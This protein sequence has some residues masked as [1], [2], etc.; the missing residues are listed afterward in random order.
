MLLGIK[1]LGQLPPKL[2]FLFYILVTAR[3]VI[4]SEWGIIVDIIRVEDLLVARCS[5]VVPRLELPISVG[6]CTFVITILV[7][8]IVIIV[9]K[10][11]LGCVMLMTRRLNSLIYYCQQFLLTIVLR[12]INLFVLVKITLM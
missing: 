11:R 4:T 8:L 6:V 2:L 12:F 5:A 10:L 1:K 3:N 7:V 9:L